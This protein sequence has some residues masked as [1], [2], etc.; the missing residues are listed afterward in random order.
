LKA[1]VQ[2]FVLYPWERFYHLLWQRDAFSSSKVIG[3]ELLR[4]LRQLLAVS[5]SFTP[6]TRALGKSHMSKNPKKVK[7]PGKALSLPKALVHTAA[8]QPC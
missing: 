7:A 6:G 4:P 1:H 8:Q 5:S 2:F 3:K